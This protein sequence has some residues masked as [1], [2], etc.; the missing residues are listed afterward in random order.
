M[1]RALIAAVSGYTELQQINAVIPEAVQFGELLR[2][3]LFGN[4]HIEYSI[5]E[6]VDRLLER[7]NGY[8]GGASL[9]DELL[10]YFSG[11]GLR[12]DEDPLIL[13]GVD[14]SERNL[15]QTTISSRMIRD[16]SLHSPS[17]SIAIVL[18]CCYSKGIIQS[19]SDA[20]SKNSDIDSSLRQQRKSIQLLCGSDK[21][22]PALIENNHSQFTQAI[23]IG[24]RNGDAGGSKPHATLSDLAEYLSLFGADDPIGTS[25][26][27]VSLGANHPL[28]IC[29]NPN[30][31]NLL[32][33]VTLTD[34]F[35]DDQRRMVNAIQT[36]QNVIES[37]APERQR[38]A[39][40]LLDLYDKLRPNATP[41]VM[42][43]LA[44]ARGK[45]N[46]EVHDHTQRPLIVVC[47]TRNVY[48][49][50]AVQK[51]IRA[52]N[53]RVFDLDRS[54]DYTYDNISLF[55]WL[56]D[57]RDAIWIVDHELRM[58][59]PHRH[60]ELFSS[61]VELPPEIAKHH[62]IF[63]TGG[64]KTSHAPLGNCK[65]F[66]FEIN[67]LE[68]CC[69][70]FLGNHDLSDPGEI[71][72]SSQ[73]L[74]K[75]AKAIIQDRETFLSAIEHHDRQLEG[76][77]YHADAVVNINSI[78]REPKFL[79]FRRAD[80]YVMAIC[81]SEVGVDPRSLQLTHEPETLAR[82]A[83]DEE[84]LALGFRIGGR[85]DPL[86]HDPFRAITRVFVDANIFF[87]FLM[88]PQSTVVIP[89]YSEPR[90]EKIN[91]TIST[92]IRALQQMY[93]E[94]IVQFANIARSRKFDDAVLRAL[95]SD[96]NVFTRFAPTPSNTLHIGSI[97]TAL[98]SYLFYV[99]D[100]DRNRFHVRF[101]DTNV[102]KDDSWRV[103][104]KIIDDLKWVGIEPEYSFSQS[105]EKS[106]SNYKRV[107]ELFEKADLISRRKDGSIELD[108]KAVTQGFTYW[109]DLKRGPQIQ[110]HIPRRSSNG[111]L[112]DY[113]LTWPGGL[114][115][116]YKFA[117][118]I[119]DIMQNSL[120]V[121]DV[122]QD[123]SA[124]TARQS[125][126]I[127]CIRHCLAYPR[128]RQSDRLIHQL[129]RAANQTNDHRSRPFPFL[130]PP[131]YLHVAR[132]C[133]ENGHS[134]SK[135]KLSV[136]HSV[137]HIRTAGLIFPETLLFWCI[138]SFGERYLRRVGL[139]D[140]HEL[141]GEIVRAGVN[142]FLPRFAERFRPIEFVDLQAAGAIRVQ[143]LRKIDHCV[144]RAVSPLR[145]KMFVLDL[146]KSN[147]IEAPRD[148][149][150]VIL[151]LH[152]ARHH[153]GGAKEVSHLAFALANICMGESEEPKLKH[154]LNFPIDASLVG[155]W[156][157]D[158]TDQEKKRVRYSI[159]GQVDGPPLRV[160]L[161]VLGA[162]FFL[163]RIRQRAPH[164][165]KFT[166]AVS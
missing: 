62:G 112:L 37:G 150:G 83:T 20:M 160:L 59:L 138:R 76:R 46:I 50:R 137:E 86:F 41:R 60:P 16:A 143:G 29:R 15:A 28:I 2:D 99:C 116:K 51:I 117:G 127:G 74:D 81:D 70:E 115:F 55:D 95:L 97:R 162:Q 101:D 151:R 34:L 119:D 30:R 57:D 165:G 124:F 18:D 63:W 131:A 140:A 104:K 122:R 94:T 123:H 25:A 126:I 64:R 163:A 58:S 132:I 14:S 27:F 125:I 107:L 89:D 21:S 145:L 8:F 82:L 10:F 128:N 92:F 159:M 42:D 26:S 148:I 100:S 52:R 17:K 11:H 134:L 108:T 48:W 98:V 91:C 105:D 44:A 106:F 129:R 19:F 39:R 79:I 102:N 156:I 1:K 144:L 61:L 141:L 110:H 153:F 121:R 164:N 158:L 43:A 114:R 103:S 113:S 75:N 65:S 135:R 54:V 118:A 136:E 31:G 38:R 71:G 157:Q 23:L 53:L 56:S 120:V 49:A 36:L 72:T 161:E 85:I 139:G 133:D 80:S 87:Q 90:D 78:V 93:G 67:D 7:I 96:N 73:I 84:L 152:S 32:S 166:E 47:N 9:T 4:Y 154:V 33:R 5:D 77:G 24:L 68:R 66:T 45:S 88:F 130:C 142:G 13:T 147:L 12:T 155:K 40:E 109:L 146:Y 149:N 3:P 111:E 6:R 22:H 69:R 35:S